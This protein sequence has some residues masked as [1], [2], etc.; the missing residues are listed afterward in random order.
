MAWKYCL[1]HLVLLES[2]VFLLEIVDLGVFF[3]NSVKFLP[4]VDIL[5]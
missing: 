4:L 1:V 3:C 2:F 5:I